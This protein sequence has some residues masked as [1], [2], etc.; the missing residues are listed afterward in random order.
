MLLSLSRS[1]ASASWRNSNNWTAYAPTCA[2]FGVTC[3]AAQT[4]VVALDLSNNNVSG[5]I[6]AS[7]SY[8]TA[9]SSLSLQNNG[10]IGTVPSV[11]ATLPSL[12]H[13]NLC[14][15]N[16]TGFAPTFPGTVDAAVTLD[17]CGLQCAPGFY[18]QPGS[19][20]PMST[21]CPAGYACPAGTGALGTANACPAGSFAV[22]GQAQCALCLP[23]TYGATAMMGVPTCSGN[24]TAAPGFACPA[25][26]T[27]P[28][29][30]ACPTN[31]ASAGNMSQCMP[32]RFWA[33]FFWGC[34]W[35]WC[36]TV[37]GARAV[38]WCVWGLSRGKRHLSS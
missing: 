25:G 29:G 8:L 13:L 10:L 30:T 9:L 24:C 17:R 6:P 4:H 1:W 31:T 35:G 18:G 2:F 23:G 36:S 15:N 38:V 32:V 19:V 11:L 12:V 26:S 7:L 20:S 28:A 37:G 34:L 3:D 16:L 22:P 21:L 5:V 27:T 33:V 14:G